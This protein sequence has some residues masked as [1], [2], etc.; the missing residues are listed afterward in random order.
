VRGG[1][2]ELE[3]TPEGARSQDTNVAGL[4]TSRYVQPFGR[5]RGRLTTAA[6]ER[7]RVELDG[8]TEDHTAV[9]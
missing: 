7:L 9:W 8:V 3:F 5:F 4:L 6:G 1:G 2:L